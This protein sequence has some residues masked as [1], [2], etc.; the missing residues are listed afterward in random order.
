MVYAILS[1]YIEHKHI[2]FLHETSVAIF[3][4]FLVSLGA[5]LSGNESFVQMVHFDDS[6]FFYI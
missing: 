2:T 1:S 6:L 5:E 4:G 3:V